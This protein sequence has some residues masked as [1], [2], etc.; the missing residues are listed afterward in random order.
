MSDG[1]VARRVLPW[2]RVVWAVT[3]LAALVTG[4]LGL[5]GFLGHL[6]PGRYG[7]RPLDIF[8]DDLQLFVLSSNPLNEEGPYPLALEFARFA[9]PAA[10]VYALLEA[11]HA[12]FA[13]RYRRWRVRSRGGNVIIVGATEAADILADKLTA[14][15]R[16]VVRARSGD[17][18]SLRAVGARRA[19]ALYAFANDSH[20]P[21]LNVA[22]AAVAA[23]LGA[24]RVYAQVSDPRVALAVRARRLALPTDDD[25]NVDVV[26]VDEVA[27][28][29]LVRIDGPQIVEMTA[30][31][32]V[33]VGTGAF[34]RAL[35]VELARYWRLSARRAERLPVTLIGRDAREVAAV[36]RREWAIAAEV[37]DLA[38]AEDCDQ[39]AGLVPYRVYVGEDDEDLALTTAL[40]ASQ[41]WHGGEGSLVVRLSRLA[42]YR[43]VFAGRSARLFDDLG[44]RMRVV[45]LTELATDPDLIGEDLVE[46]LAQVIHERYLVDQLRRGGT[47]G[48]KAFRHWYDLDDSYRSANRR[49]ARDIGRKLEMIGCTVAPSFATAVPFN[50]DDAEVDLL[51]RHEHDRWTAERTKDG[52]RPGP[53]DDKAKR[54]PDLVPWEQLDEPT[55]D[56]DRQVVRDLPV[57]LAEAGLRVVRLAARPVPAQ[58]SA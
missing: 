7:T 13:S 57:V 58:P 6:P 19:A 56:K 31:N 9:A 12:L 2:T 24:R 39:V 8:Y 46:R 4:Y 34:A 26:H 47:W 11:G 15:H 14:F 42:S 49:Q 55:R 29:A 36:L 53:R 40:T 18:E 20:D 1:V 10:T 30:P 51:A 23:S 50:L 48:E 35:V 33:I 38:S 27:A 5:R 37:C 52:W 54:H 43:T 3:V 45:G 41:L 28:R 25:R 21:V 32:I 44:R 16:R 22:T 17:E